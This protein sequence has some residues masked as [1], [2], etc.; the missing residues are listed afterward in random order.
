MGSKPLILHSW[1]AFYF[2]FQGAFFNNTGI[3]VQI[4]IKTIKSRT[5][6][7]KY[8]VIWYGYESKKN[9]KIKTR[10]PEILVYFRS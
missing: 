2:Q 3:Q 9:K 5:C 1:E 6:S 7:K 8:V 10:G 4:Q